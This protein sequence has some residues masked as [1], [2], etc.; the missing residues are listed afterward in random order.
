MV[1]LVMVIVIIGLLAAVVMPKFFD[2]KAEAQSAAEEGTV[3]AVRSGI[4]LAHLSNLAQGSDTYPASLDSASVGA[5]SE[6]NP[7]FTEVIEGGVTDGNWEKT[8]TGYTYTPSGSAYTYT[9]GTGVFAK[10]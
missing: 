1:E 2:I 6:S 8:A 3:A 5:A 10:T 9:S 7:I 4:K